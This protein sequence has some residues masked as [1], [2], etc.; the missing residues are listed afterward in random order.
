MDAPRP[1]SIHIVPKIEQIFRLRLFRAAIS[2]EPKDTNPRQSV[3]DNP[4]REK[5]HMSARLSATLTEIGVTGKIVRMD[6]HTH[7][8]AGTLRCF[9]IT[10]GAGVQSE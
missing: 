7:A 2:G 8:T 1:T 3:H 9:R 6:F 10:S 5:H 4:S